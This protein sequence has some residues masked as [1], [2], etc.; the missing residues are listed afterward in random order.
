[1]S[2]R[3]AT[4]TAGRPADTRPVEVRRAEWLENYPDK[5]LTCRQGHNFPKPAPGELLTGTRIMPYHDEDHPRRAGHFY[6]EQECASCGRLRWRITGPR[7]AYASQ[8]SKW[9]YKDP[10]GYAAPPGLGL[11]RGDYGD[12]YMDRLIAGDP[13]LQA[14]LAARALENQ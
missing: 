2:T 1:M 13:G 11:T 5:Y 7:G 9:M 4:V 10:R 14:E 3:Y 6:Q 8:A 12:R